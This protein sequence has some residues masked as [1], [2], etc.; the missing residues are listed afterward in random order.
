M[1]PDVDPA[2]VLRA[3][4]GDRSAFRALVDSLSPLVFNLAWR[5]TYRRDDAE[6]VTQ[7][8]FIRLFRHLGTYDP[9]LPFLPWFRTLATNACLSWRKRE[10]SARS[11][12][13]DGPDRPEPA[14]PEAE[15]AP[16][17][18]PALREAILQLPP[19]YRMVL[20]KLYF[21]GQSIEEISKQMRAPTGT[22]KT[23]LF[24]AREQLK[25]RLKGH[26]ENL[27]R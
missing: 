21:E 16:E 14:A 6:D 18:S 11:A 19:E 5:I 15:P 27:M 24:R 4:S 10:A 17:P 20:A 25:D 9:S 12:S 7:E 3:R 22:I 1:A 13:L 26:A 2:L 8:V 23:W